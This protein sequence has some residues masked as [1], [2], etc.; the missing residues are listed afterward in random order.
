MRVST[1]AILLALVAGRAFCQSDS[2][3]AVSP[4]V[5]SAESFFL[6]VQ[7]RLGMVGVSMAEWSQPT[8]EESI[9]LTEQQAKELAAIVVDHAA[10]NRAYLFSLAPLRR[11]AL[12]QSIESGQVSEELVRRIQ[13][14]QN[15]HAKMVFN[16][17]QRVQTAL[18]VPLFHALA[19]LLEKK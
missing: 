7:A 19:A 12:F 9:G 4:D 18:G 13:N 14:L 15:E 6:K 10:K 11:A 8:I 17:R 16:Q 5:V 3:W 2:L 1:P